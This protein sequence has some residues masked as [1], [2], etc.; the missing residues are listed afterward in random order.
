MYT[1]PLF[2]ISIPDQFSIASGGP[3][4]QQLSHRLREH[5][6]LLRGQRQMELESREFTTVFMLSTN[7]WAIFRYAP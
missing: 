1:I 3:R 6:P 4:R 7:H 2:K 5:E